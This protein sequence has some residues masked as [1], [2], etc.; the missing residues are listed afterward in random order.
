[1]NNHFLWLV[2]H[3]ASTNQSEKGHRKK[4]LS[5][6]SLSSI[7]KMIKNIPIPSSES[8][9]YHILL[10]IQHFLSSEM[11]NNVIVEIYD[12]PQAKIEFW[13]LISILS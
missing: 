2:L 3:L 5:A 6:E 9:F 10:Q 4:P 13:F 1:M 11:L 12:Q 7:E 8:I